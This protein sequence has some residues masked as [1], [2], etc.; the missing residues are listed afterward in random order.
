[1][2][3]T[4]LIA[5]SSLILH[6]PFLLIA[7]GPVSPVFLKSCLDVLALVVVG[8]ESG[9]VV[10]GSLLLDLLHPVLG[11]LVHSR[12]TDFRVHL[13]LSE[14]SHVGAFGFLH[15]LLPGS[16]PLVVWVCQEAVHLGVGN[17]HPVSI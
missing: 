13:F 10:A 11:Q 4:A 7:S 12:V 17:W 16:D 3:L 9:P 5:S 2:R 8:V 6:Q 1:M 15:H 14:S